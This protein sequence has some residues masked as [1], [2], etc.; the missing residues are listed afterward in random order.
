MPKTSG[1]GTPALDSA[2]TARRIFAETAAINKNATR[3][4]LIFFALDD[5]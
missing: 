5:F 2:P 3:R 4:I 1:V